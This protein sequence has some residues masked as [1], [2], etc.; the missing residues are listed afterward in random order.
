MTDL[1]LHYAPSS[2]D[3]QIVLLTLIEKNVPFSGVVVDVDDLGHID[4]NY[5]RKASIC[6]VPMLEHD[7][8]AITGTAQ[9][10]DY[11]EQQFDGADLRQG[12]PAGIDHWITRVSTA[13]IEELTLATPPYSV[14]F[15]RVISRKRLKQQID[16]ANR[17]ARDVHELGDIYREHVRVLRHQFRTLGDEWKINDF[18][19][20]ISVVLD[21]LELQLKSSPYAAGTH[22]T[23]ADIYLTALIARLDALGLAYLWEEEERPSVFEYVQRVKSRPSYT[24]VFGEDSTP[25][26]FS[27]SFFLKTVLAGSAI[28]VSVLA[29][30]VIFILLF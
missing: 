30:G 9:I 12:D 27:D 20:N 13:H 8:T 25:R 2:F 23:M 29:I 5:V 1:I 10:I 3:S 16:I 15:A 24:K 28:P 22:Y 19:R 18:Y 26:L 14:P 11:I 21:A 7:E 4:P 17:L 6:G